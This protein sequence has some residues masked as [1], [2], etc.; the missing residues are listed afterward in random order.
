MRKKYVF[1]IICILAV[2]FLIIALLLK[3]RGD[4]LPIDME[5]ENISK[6]EIAHNT[7]KELKT[8]ES[9]KYEEFL[10]ILAS[11]RCKRTDYDENFK[12]D[13]EKNDDVLT[14]KP[15]GRLDTFTSPELGRLLEGRLE[16][17]RHVVVDFSHVDYL[18]SAGLRI[19]LITQQDMEKKDGRNIIP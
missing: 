10:S 17:I 8:I 5:S 16:D 1:G 2:M 12:V 13:F 9:E 11:I 6:I 4:R 7:G 3:N 14:I 15:S 19:L 18:S